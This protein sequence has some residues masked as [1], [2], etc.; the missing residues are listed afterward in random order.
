MDIWVVPICCYCEQCRLW[1]SACKHSVKTCARSECPTLSTWSRHVATHEE[2]CRAAEVQTSRAAC[3]P[4]RVLVWALRL[5]RQGRQQGLCSVGAVWLAL[6]VTPH[7][8]RTV[9]TVLFPVLLVIS[10]SASWIPAVPATHTSCHSPL[11]CRKQREPAYCLSL[12]SFKTSS[13]TWEANCR[14]DDEDVDPSQNKSMRAGARA[15]CAQ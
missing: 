2:F 6:T 8:P 1:A 9:T 4:Q 12:P 3:F 14:A 5:C 13:T 7:P 11:F 15:A 10:A